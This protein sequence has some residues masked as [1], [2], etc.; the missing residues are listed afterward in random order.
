MTVSTPAP[1]PSI[2]RDFLAP[3]LLAARLFGRYWPQLMLLAALGLL[4]RDLLLM[5]AVAV[6]LEN[7]LAGM[8]VLSFVVL[9][10]LAVT[11]LMFSALRP[12]LPAI[13]GLRQAKETA[14]DGPGEAAPTRLMSLVAIAILPFFAYYAA[15]GFL[16]DTVREYSRLALAKVPFGE[17]ADFLDLLTSQWLLASI[18]ACWLLRWLVKRISRRSP[19]PLWSFLIVAC[20]A[21]WIFIGLYAL[22]TW[23]EQLFAWLGSGGFFNALPDLDGLRS[24]LVG[25]AWAAGDFVPVELRDP[26]LWSDA[27]GLFF[28]ILLP[29]VWLVMAAI[30]YGYDA[31]ADEPS[32]GLSAA[33]RR[34]TVFGWLKD[35]L[36]HFIADYR[37]RYMPV[38][39]CV[40][41][42][43]G[44]GLGTLI[45]LVVGYR[46]IGWLGA[47]L[48]VAATRLIGA[49]ELSTW[50]V[51][52]EPISLLIGSL[53]DLDGGVLLDPL[54]ICLLAAVIER[55]VASRTADVG[56]PGATRTEDN[57]AARPAG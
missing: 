7:A 34:G 25:Q 10:K 13:R 56:C 36:D 12:D 14:E 11:V 19:W 52:V 30:V 57:T 1:Q 22:S 28:Y 21:S 49:H 40:R 15:W 17:S 16:G 42:A 55:A 29:L 23:Q 43:L 24:S 46:L 39:R 26:G 35:F 45:A 8:I 50:Q 51:I 41:M 18:A 32:T 3:L 4:I 47:W 38:L 27:Q 9:T 6:G 44:A 5:A 48:W 53:S 2:A 33:T 54:R 20:D 37:A 31:A